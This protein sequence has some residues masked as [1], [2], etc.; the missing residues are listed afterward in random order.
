MAKKQT[1][2][3]KVK[4][5]NRISVKVMKWY[6]DDTRGTLRLMTRFIK[7]TDLSELQNIE[8]NK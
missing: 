6:Q 8:I 1:F 2:D 3:S 7:V 5:D 4:Q